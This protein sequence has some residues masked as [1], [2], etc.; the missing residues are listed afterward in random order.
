MSIGAA[1]IS[2]LIVMGCSMGMADISNS[3]ACQS[4]SNDI[5]MLNI[6][7]SNGNNSKVLLA[8]ARAELVI[9]YSVTITNTI[10]LVISNLME[11]VVTNKSGLIYTTNWYK[12]WIRMTNIIITNVCITNGSSIAGVIRAELISLPLKESDRK[13]IVHYS[14]DSNNWQSLEARNTGKTDDKLWNKF[15][16]SLPFTPYDI[17]QENGGLKY[18]FWIEYQVTN[19]SYLAD[20]G[21]IYH[22]SPMPDPALPNMVIGQSVVG[23]RHLLLE[24][25]FVTPV[26]DVNGGLTGYNFQGNIQVKNVDPTNKIVKI[27]YQLNTTNWVRANISK[28]PYVYAAKTGKEFF[29]NGYTNK[30]QGGGPVCMEN[31]EFSHVFPT[32]TTIIQFIDITL[33]DG[34]SAWWS[35]K[36]RCRRYWITI[37]TPGKVE[38]WSDD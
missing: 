14:S 16:F 38:S 37:P 27:I 1:A 32:N 8:W 35:D 21:R 19:V 17:S 30:N 36:N 24:R 9:D 5:S 18:Y 12:T 4:E 25:A 23:Y 2:A 10:P 3:D 6:V 26:Y 13:M 11:K 33:Y 34:E 31:W 22:A 15:M 7:I 28:Y 20:K 29:A